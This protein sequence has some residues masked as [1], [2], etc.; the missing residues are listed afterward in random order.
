M[1]TDFEDDDP[2]DVITAREAKAIASL[3]RLARAWPDSLRLISMDGALHIIH[4]DDPRF[5]D[6]GFTER[7]ESIIADI[8]G[9]PNE[10]GAW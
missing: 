10:G 2:F 7:Q 6:E 9:I 3:K 4:T 1:S 5:H 8:S